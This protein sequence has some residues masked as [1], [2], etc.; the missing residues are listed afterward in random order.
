[1]TGQTF[2]VN[3][4]TSRI[5]VPFA[6]K[7]LRLW[8]NTAATSLTS[9]QS[10]QL[11]PNT[12]GYEWDAGRR[13]RLPPERRVQAL[14]RRPSAASRSSP[15]TAARRR[16]TRTAT[17]NLTH[18]P[19]AQRR[20]R[21]RRRHRAV[22]LGPRRLEPATARR[23]IATCEQAT[24]N[25]LA[26]MGAQP[27]TMPV[28]PDRGLGVDRQHRADLDDH[29]LPVDGGR[30]LA[31]DDLRHRVRHGRRRRRRRRGLD[32]R[33]HDLA[34]G[35]RHHELD[36][37]VDRPRQPLD[38]ASRCA[39]STTAA[40]CRRPA[41]AS[42]VNV[43]CPCS[44]WGTS[45]ATAQRRRRLRRPD[46]GRGRASSSRPTTSAPS[47]ACASTRPRP[48]PAR[49]SARCGRTDGTR[50]AQATFTGETGSGWQTVTFA[51]PVQV[52]AGHDLHRVLLRAQRPLRGHA[53][54]TSTAIPRPGPTAAARPTRRRC[55]PSATPARTTNGVYTYGASSTFPTNSFGAANYWVDVIFSPIAGARARSPT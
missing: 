45:T 12:L 16:S 11:A 34:P 5:T 46:A 6:Y 21:V 22:G 49:T 41:P 10:L 37:H 14:R 35:D 18:V 38:R 20:A 54:T 44:L 26:D 42:T 13:Q 47:P 1:M 23:P 27:A 28:G 29:A 43:N 7:N 4:G 48:T 40:T 25:L 3:S 31:G 55:T 30:R 51:S 36:L 24:V 15:T 2:L 52:H 53:P 9:G 39:P 33:R 8:R 32:R 19:R 17:H 50:L